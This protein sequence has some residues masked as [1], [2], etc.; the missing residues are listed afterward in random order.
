MPSVSI[1]VETSRPVLG[2]LTVKEVI[3]GAPPCVDPRSPRGS[4]PST[5]SGVKRN[6][7]NERLG[8]MI[9]LRPVTL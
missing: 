3:E 5:H 6:L 8:S 4:E 1:P 7:A 2:H 9:P